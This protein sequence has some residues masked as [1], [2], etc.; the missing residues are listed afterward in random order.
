MPTS[1]PADVFHQLAAALSAG[2]WD[3]G[4]AFYAEDAVVELPFAL[5]APARVRGRATL[6]ERFTALGAS[7]F[8]ITVDNIRVH[9]TD[10]PE[11]IIAEFDYRGRA[12]ATGRDFAVANI[13]VL[14]I[15]DGLI[16]AT[17]DFHDHVI[18]AL[19]TD[20]FAALTDALPG[21]SLHRTPIAPDTAA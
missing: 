10:D 1:T 5:P 2:A 14:R 7:S 12:L 16:V 21:A 13:Q 11:V 6:H 17:R 3:R 9:G 18:L 20:N 15:R 4:S 19:A 8:D